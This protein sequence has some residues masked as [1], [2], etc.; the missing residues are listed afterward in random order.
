MKTHTANSLSSLNFPHNLRRSFCCIPSSNARSSLGN[1]HGGISQCS[2]LETYVVCIR[3]V[4]HQSI[5]DQH[6]L[7]I[8][9]GAHNAPYEDFG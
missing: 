8:I 7:R 6:M 2:T 5:N 3:R 1:L 9:E 4:D